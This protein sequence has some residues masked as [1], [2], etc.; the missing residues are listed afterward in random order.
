MV[1]FGGIHEVTQELNDLVALD[2]IH[3][4]WS[5]IF[6]ETGATSPQRMAQNLNNGSPESSPMPIAR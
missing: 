5:I 1:I 4:R 2:L 3:H 6:E